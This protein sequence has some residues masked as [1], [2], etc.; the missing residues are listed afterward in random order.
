MA[1]RVFTSDYAERTTLRDGTPVLLRLVKRDDIGTLRRGFEHW[2]PESRYARFLAPK[3]RLTDDE[4]RYLCDVDQEN[5]FAL[6]AIREASDDGGEP[7]GLAIARFIRLPDV[8]GEPVT[9]EAAIAVADEA[10]GKGLGRLL[11]MRLVAAA[12]ER[13]IERFRC[14]VLRSNQT[15]QTLIDDVAPEHSTQ[16]GSGVLTIDFALP[17]ASA[18]ETEHAESAMYRF[19]RAAA[20]G[21]VEWTEWVRRF[22]RGQD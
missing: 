20:K 16:S 18:T 5:H 11:F 8:E 19:F 21:A 1:A 13:G 14:E 2:S 22:W 15:M 6:G 3:Q 9:A 4:L 7:V 10:Q 12:T 17:H